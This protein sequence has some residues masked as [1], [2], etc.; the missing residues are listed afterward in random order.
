M[1]LNEYQGQ[2]VLPTAQTLLNLNK[3][4]NGNIEG[5]P[6]NPPKSQKVKE[7][8]AGHKHGSSK[9][10]APSASHHVPKNHGFKNTPF[11][12]KLKDFYKE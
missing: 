4:E 2:P 9:H 6:Y 3:N 11:A 10:K 5:N 8:L 1:S 12:D 7:Q